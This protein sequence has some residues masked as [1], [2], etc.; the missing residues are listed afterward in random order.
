[1][2]RRTALLLL[3]AIGSAAAAQADRPTDGRTLFVR[4]CGP[5][6]GAGPAP[7]GIAMLPGTA[8][9]QAKYKGSLSPYLENRADL[10]ADV[11]RVILRNGQG[12]MPMFRKTEV[13]DAEIAAIAA[14]LKAS[15]GR[16]R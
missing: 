16:A 13:T 8:A 15:A 3:G 14:Y 1:M 4:T 10:D 2:T 7:D 6:H 12:G 5:C 9:L 11:L